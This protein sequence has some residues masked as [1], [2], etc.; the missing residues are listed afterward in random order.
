M[1]FTKKLGIYILFILFAGIFYV[2]N[3]RYLLKYLYPPKIIHVKI[4]GGVK[5]P[6]IYDIEEGKTVENLV[7]IAGGLLGK[8]HLSDYEKGK[9]L[10]DSEIIRI[11]VITNDGK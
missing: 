5:N 2:N 7:I 9:I 8:Y 1:H 6:G 4:T 3:N 11:G 10:H